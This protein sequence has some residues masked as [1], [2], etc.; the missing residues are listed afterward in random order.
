MF[1]RLVRYP[2]LLIAAIAAAI[3]ILYE[4]CVLFFAYTGDA[5]VLSDVVVLS[6]Q[7]EGPISSLPV[8]DN[9]A[10]S[11]GQTLFEIDRTPFEL[12]VKGSEASL[13]QAQANLALAQDELTAG[14]AGVAS[15]EAVA[16]N[17]QAA[18]ARAQQLAK[19]GFASTANLDIARRDIDTA[20]AAI[21]IAQAQLAVSAQRIAVA[22][23]AIDVA[24]SRLAKDRYF[25]S[26]TVVTA[27]YAGRVAPF[28]VRLG[29]YLETGTPVMALVTGNRRR[30]VANL[31]ER[32]LARVRPGQ[33]V[34]LTLGSDPWRIHTGH[35]TGISPGIA[36]TDSNQPVLPYVQPTTDWVRLPRRFPVEIALDAWP[37]ALPL[38][39]GADARVVIWF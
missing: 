16:T 25:L 32:H 28:T 33:R 10:V 19:D 27:E 17:A 13:E 26:K 5:Y 15:A 12:A 4:V 34:W 8:H 24:E 36:R 39:V 2:V 30:I 9:E 21:Q 35:V 3:F 14:K 31:N 6:A 29:D 38:F 23:A 7:I 1:A 20:A 18:F 37:T 22:T 11:E